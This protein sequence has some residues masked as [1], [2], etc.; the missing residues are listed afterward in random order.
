MGCSILCHW[1]PCCLSVVLVA[2]PCL[3]LCDPMD[4]TPAG[5][6]VHGTSQAGMLEWVAIFFSRSPSC[7]WTKLCVLSCFSHIQLCSTLRTVACQSPQSMGFS[8]QESWSG[9]PCPPP[10][11]L[12]DPGIKPESLTTPALACEFFTTSGTWE[13]PLGSFSSVTQL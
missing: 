8:R 3:T 1:G 12:P 4:C 9:L 5:S 13:A 7:V 11:N 6:S 10:G 2:Q